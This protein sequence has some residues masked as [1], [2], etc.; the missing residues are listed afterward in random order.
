[1]LDIIN[2]PSSAGMRSSSS[3]SVLLFGVLTD[4]GR[5]GLEI[6]GSV[7]FYNFK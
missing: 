2:E 4:N 7:H 6:H 5:E 1:M 3:I